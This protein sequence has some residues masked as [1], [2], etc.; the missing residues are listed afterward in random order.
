MSPAGSASQGS[1]RKIFNEMETA[2][3]I[4]YLLAGSNG[5]VLKH[6]A[7]KEAAEEQQMRR[8]LFGGST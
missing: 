6:D 4:R 2:A 7:Y 5:G 8:L 3:A 1:K